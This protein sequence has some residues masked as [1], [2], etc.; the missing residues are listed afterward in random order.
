MA[1]AKGWPSLLVPA[2]LT[3]TFGYALG[4]FVGLALG[5]H[6]LRP[7]ALGPGVAAA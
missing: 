2:V 5:E 1:V 3:S 4:S 7:M 6:V